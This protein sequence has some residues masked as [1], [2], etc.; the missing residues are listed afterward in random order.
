MKGT[1]RSAIVLAGGR[2]LRMGADK[3]VLPWDGLTVLE[4]MVARLARAF[5]DVVV[6]AAPN[7]ELA[8]LSPTTRVIRDAEPFQGPVKA[9]Y[10]GL[11][12]IGTDVAFAC[13]CDM[14]FLDAALA[15]WLCDVSAG[16]DAAMPMVAGRLQVLHAAYR[17]SCL[18]VLDAMVQRGERALHRVGSALDAR[19]VDE[20]ELR[21]H[22]P[23]LL[24]FFNVN[25]PQ[26]YAR[27]RRIAAATR[28]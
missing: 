12:T 22:D 8:R 3:A 19:L 6:V 1:G 24:S 11:S 14:P 20:D 16:R 26:D 13:A 27:A 10:L 18:R 21:R 23:E 25:T 17:T 5:Q 2:S 28:A 4:S 15:A 7:Q 9:L